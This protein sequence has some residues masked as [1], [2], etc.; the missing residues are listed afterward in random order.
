[1][2]SFWGAHSSF[3]HPPPP[4][5]A[6][7]W[8]SGPAPHLPGCSLALAIGSNPSFAH[9]FPG[10]LRDV[11]QASA[12]PPRLGLGPPLKAEPEIRMWGGR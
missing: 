8:R 7:P 12:R 10:G 9:A 5:A 11:H 6:L 1:M 2:Q 4:A 3:G